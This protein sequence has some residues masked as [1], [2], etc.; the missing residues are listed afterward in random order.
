MLA[1]IPIVLAG[2]SFAMTQSFF[3]GICMAL[4]S[5]R[6]RTPNVGWNPDPLYW[7]VTGDLG[8]DSQ[9]LYHRK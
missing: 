4:L 9:L 1:S 2:G 7:G 8:R 6:Q 5:M 3:F